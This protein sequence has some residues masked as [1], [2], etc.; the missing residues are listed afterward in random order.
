MVRPHRGR[1]L[2]PAPLTGAV[3]A[4]RV[5]FCEGT[6]AEGKTVMNPANL[7]AEQQ[8]TAR[9]LAPLEVFDPD[10]A[11]EAIGSAWAAGPALLVFIRHFG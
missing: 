4:S 3:P 9:R 5:R 10:G 2:L 1:R 11:P 8:E 6:R 7:T